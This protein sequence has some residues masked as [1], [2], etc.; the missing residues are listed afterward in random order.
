M[1][2]T[3]FK[4]TKFLLALIFFCESVLSYTNTVNAEDLY[5]YSPPEDFVIK[6]SNLRENI[7]CNYLILTTHAFCD[8]QDL[9]RFV[10]H[11]SSFDSLKLSIVTIEQIYNQFPSQTST[12]A[13]KNFLHYAYTYW[14]KSENSQVKLTY[15]LIIGDGDPKSSYF[16]PTYTY[17]VPGDSMKSD[18]WFACLDDDNDDGIVNNADYDPDLLIGRF[19]V[20]NESEL[21]AIVDKTIQHDLSTWDHDRRRHISL[22]SSFDEKDERLIIDDLYEQIQNLIEKQD[23]FKLID[24][25]KLTETEKNIFQQNFW[26]AL[27]RGSSIININAHGSLNAWSDGHGWD[28][29]ADSCIDSLSNENKCPIILNFSCKSGNFS[30]PEQDC[31]GEKLLYIQTTG[32]V[33][34]YGAS[35]NNDGSPHFNKA[36]LE[37]IIAHK[38]I[39]IGYHINLARKTS[40]P[41]KCYNLL[42]D[43]ALRIHKKKLKKF[44]DLTID[45]NNV[46]VLN[47]GNLHN[48][49]LKL[50]I[51]ISNKGFHNAQNV[52]LVVYD[53]P[54]ENGGNKLFETTLDEVATKDGYNTSC[55]IT[56]GINDEITYY[57]ELDPENKIPEFDELNNSLFDSSKISIFSINNKSINFNKYRRSNRPLP[58]D[59]NSD[60]EIDLY[61]FGKDNILYVNFGDLD[62]KIKE[63]PFNLPPLSI[64]DQAAVLDINNNRAADIFVNSPLTNKFFILYE[65]NNVNPYGEYIVQSTLLDFNYSI[66]GFCDIDNNG[67]LEPFTKAA[68]FILLENDSGQYD[69][70]RCLL[71]IPNE[72]SLKHITFADYDTD[73]YTDIFVID[74]NSKGYLLRNNGD[75]TFTD[76][77]QIID[78]HI[79][80]NLVNIIFND[81]NNDAKSDIFLVRGR[82]EAPI[83]LHYEDST[84]QEVDFTFYPQLSSRIDV[85]Y[86]FD[87][88]N[89]G[90]SDLYIQD[91]NSIGTLYHNDSNFNFHK[92][93]NFLPMDLPED[94][95]GTTF[96]DL[97]ND[98]DIDILASFNDSYPSLRFLNNELSDNNWVKI[99]LMGQQSN[100]LGMGATVFVYTNQQVQ[101]RNINYQTIKNICIDPSIHFGLSQTTIIDSIVI[102]WPSGIKDVVKNCEVNRTLNLS[103]GYGNKEIPIRSKLLHN[104]PNPFNDH[105]TINYKIK[106]NPHDKKSSYKVNIKI[107]NI[108]GQEV[109]NLVDE[110]K[111][112]GEYSIN[113]HGTDKFG[114]TLASGIYL[115]RL[116]TEGYYEQSKLLLLK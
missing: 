85:A 25:C 16:F 19:P 101:I 97:D 94:L 36:I 29:F 79:K 86:F 80:D 90:F 27:N 88:D 65:I 34:F 3:F 84:F 109:I 67:I 75:S 40:N 102:K 70:T 33:A 2:H 82:F 116:H 77:S 110:N 18:H 87:Y 12:Q 92:I 4:P 100:S 43:P 11:R 45:P 47:D 54:P 22:F 46:Y 57:I 17:I 76:V 42:G 81:L 39:P 99:N 107:F 8:N 10:H 91:K 37:S 61:M 49:S 64:I 74:D 53:R 51:N 78:F 104:F 50:H 111:Y 28:F 24:A 106:G 115:I 31:L 5:L 112:S 83:I 69:S 95:L 66:L 71:P 32:A 9:V 68:P 14:N 21:K 55:L 62:Y 96:T 98:G 108:L 113:W 41:E 35:S 59:F 63:S 73:S 44:I 114:Q 38:N 15:V 1:L 89:D 26:A 13:I 23:Y 105:T 72:V 52:A 20:D 56:P 6:P 103:E 93:K 7:E 48:Y 58:F 60:G 30:H